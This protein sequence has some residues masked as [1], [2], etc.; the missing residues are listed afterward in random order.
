MLTLYFELKLQ[1]WDY[2]AAM[3]IVEEAGGQVSQISGENVRFDK[4]ISILASNNQED[5]IKYIVG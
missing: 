5:Y 1:P 4:P 3:L 2:A